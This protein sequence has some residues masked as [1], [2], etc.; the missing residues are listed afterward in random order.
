MPKIAH[1][2]SRPSLITHLSETAL[3]ALY[4]LRNWVMS[5]PAFIQVMLIFGASRLWGWAVFSTVA[6]QQYVS[7]WGNGPLSYSQF[8]GMWDAGWYERIAENGYP[9]S[10]PTNEAGTVAQNT[11]AFMPAFPLTAKA[12]ATIFKT[13]Y[14]SAAIGLALISSFLAAWVIYLLFSE[15][16]LLTNY[17]KDQTKAENEVHSLALWG[18]AVLGFAPIS[19]V[20]Q[21]PYAESYNLIFLAAT[22]YL[23]LRQRYLLLLPCAALTCFSRPVG[24]PL[25]ATL[26]LWWA[27]ELLRDIR[28][29]KGWSEAFTQGLSQLVSALAVCAFAL[30]WPAIAWAVTGQADAYTATETAWRGSDLT[31]LTPWFTQSIHYLGYAGPPLFLLA[32]LAFYTALVTPLTQ[33]V[34]PAPLRLWCASFMTYLAL[35]WFPQS[36]TFRMMLPLFVLI[37]PLVALS[38]S[39]AYRW[40]L[41]VSGASL[42]CAWVGWLWHWKQLPGGGDFPP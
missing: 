10:L 18:V 1:P 3:A 17:F 15:A 11:W 14:M 2:N 38:T 34:L 42:Q 21:V 7:P 9:Y 24:V 37:L 29:G 22:L 26:G 33:R 5:L 28:Q 40:L 16:L 41:I 35:F 19:A 8:L 12:L 23:L 6:A 27:W 36:S 13:D 31:L 30:A 25:G 39:K 20:L 32:L 4:T